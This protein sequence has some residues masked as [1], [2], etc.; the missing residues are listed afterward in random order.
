MLSPFRL[1][2]ANGLWRAHLFNEGLRFIVPQI[3]MGARRAKQRIE[4]PLGPR[5][6]FLLAYNRH[7]H[8]HELPGLT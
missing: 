1:F 7:R 6:I 8:Y 5:A 4:S 3:R 2:Y